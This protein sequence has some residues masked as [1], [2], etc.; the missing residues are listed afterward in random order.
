MC[1][2]KA[3]SSSKRAQHSE[4]SSIVCQLF[5]MTA[6]R[7]CPYL[8]DGEPKDYSQPINL[9]QMQKADKSGTLA[10]LHSISNVLQQSD[11]PALGQ[12]RLQRRFDSLW[13][14]LDKS[15]KAVRLSTKVRPLVRAGG[16]KP[17]TRIAKKR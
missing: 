11:I 1:S 7:V 8:L 2:E 13:P 6:N 10:L 4:R 14:D 12:E 9:F 17:P 16:K 5:A 15:L 3:T